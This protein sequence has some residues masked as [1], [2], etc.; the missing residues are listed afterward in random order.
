MT[1]ADDRH[2]LK[3]PAAYLDGTNALCDA[4]AESVESD[5]VGMDGSTARGQLNAIDKLRPILDR[6]GI[7]TLDGL[8]DV[9]ALGDLRRALTQACKDGDM[10]A[11]GTAREYLQRFAKRCDAL[12]L[13]TP[14]SERL[15]GVFKQSRKDAGRPVEVAPEITLDHMRALLGMMDV[16]LDTPT[17][18]RDDGSNTDAV[19]DLV[20]HRGRRLTPMQRDRA[21]AWI[22]LQVS[23]S[24]RSGS[25]VEIT[26]GD[27][28]G[29]SVD[30]LLRKG[31]VDPKRKRFRI[32]DDY[33]RFM[34]PLL[35]R[36]GDDPD[37]RLFTKHGRETQ[38]TVRSLLL[39]I[40]WPEHYGRTGLHN[41]RKLFYRAQY[42]AGNT[43]EVAA[44][45]LGNTPA[46]AADHYADFVHA[47]QNEL[48]LQTWA[49][50]MGA[51]HAPEMDWDFAPDEHV[52]AWEHISASHPWTL[53][54]NPYDD[55]DAEPPE[56]LNGAWRFRWVDVIEPTWV[57]FDASP[58]RL[59]AYESN[60]GDVLLRH[61]GVYRADGSWV[62]DVDGSPVQRDLWL[63]R[64]GLAEKWARPDLNC[65]PCAPLESIMP[66]YARAVCAALDAGDLDTVRRM[67]DLLVALGGEAI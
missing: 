21:L 49:D 41:L 12:G 17:A 58:Q 35:E 29:R 8:T 9:D 30:F 63:E 50:H 60:Q 57:Q 15:R 64:G 19:G 53:I 36:V 55:P 43:A 52:I 38:G 54:L 4:L 62:A 66:G 13:S 34:P 39:S 31:H 42:E 47:A 61:Y 10:G 33:L 11:P 28:R 44:A 59:V 48:S 32:L 37:A 56:A 3:L 26:R 67:L 25:V 27:V 23:G 45:G 20:G 40:G 18:R 5:R 2:E 24:I 1:P 46:V 16:W 14:D 65:A 7:D 51:A 22:A 6:V